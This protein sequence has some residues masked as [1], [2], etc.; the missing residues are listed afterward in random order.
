MTSEPKD[1]VRA[2]YNALRRALED[3]GAVFKGRKN[4]K[5]CFHDDVSP[6][7]SVHQ[8]QQGVW[9]FTCHGCGWGGDVFDVLAK[10]GGKSVEDLLKAVREESTRPARGRRAAAT[11]PP[12]P[13]AEEVPVRGVKTY[14]SPEAIKA[15]LRDVEATYPYTNPD[16]GKAELVI[17]RCRTREGKKTFIQA[18][19]QADGSWAMVAPPKP[20]PLFNRTR[21]RGA[22]QIVVVEGE[23][24]VKK[25]TDLGVRGTSFTTSPGGAG[26][27][28]YADWSPL[29]GKRVILWPDNDPPDP[30]RNKVRQGVRHMEEVADELRKLSPPPE[31]CWLDPDELAIPDK[32]DIVEFCAFHGEGTADSEREAVEQALRLAVPLPGPNPSGALEQR[33][34]ETIAGKRRAIPWKF[35]VLSKFTRACLPGTI[36]L[37]CGDPGSTKS[38]LLLEQMWTWHKEGIPVALYELEEDQAY[39]L[40][41]ALAQVDGNA[42]LDDSDWVE[43]HPDQARAAYHRHKAF[44]DS[45]APRVFAEPG[46]REKPQVTQDDLVAWAREQAEKGAR[47][48]GI[49]P[50]TVA[51]PCRGQEKSFTPDLKFMVE[52]K[53][54]AREFAC[55]IVLVTHPKESTNA[56][57][58]PLMDNM[59]GGRAYVRFAQ[60]VLWIK[61]L[62][63]RQ[64]ML[65]ETERDE[66]ENLEIER[67]IYLVKTRNGRGTG[68]EIGFEFDPRSLTFVEKGVIVREDDRS[69]P[70]PAPAPAPGPRPSV[71]PPVALQDPFAEDAD[72]AAPDPEPE[73]SFDGVLTQA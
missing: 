23:K 43:Q 70:A 9:R 17:F 69:P 18:S 51:A 44:M 66:L 55:S 61:R 5:C 32:G 48:I 20:W 49:D 67:L 40:N 42:K 29:A 35:R 34:E 73:L 30:K 47:I 21:V 72:A 22:G 24:C 50:V 33:I 13:A 14:P 54:I 68:W 3:A 65:V 2:N 12:A 63:N 8:D 59:A 15:A 53:L 71:R 64:V 16:T 26:K 46:T 10:D 56:K 45:F 41:R 1:A 58:R 39:H 52:M 60:T 57:A 37:L 38:Y 36:T 19:P 4:V 62:E 27:A 31:I 11:P 25:G 7:G 6:S 28:A